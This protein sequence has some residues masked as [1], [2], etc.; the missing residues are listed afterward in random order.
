M[1]RK[2]WKSP[3]LWAFLGIESV[4]YILLLFGGGQVAVISSF[5]SIVLCFL[6]TLIGCKNNSLLAI[7]AMACTVGADFCLVICSPR[8]QLWGMVFFS[9]VQILY[10]IRLHRLVKYKVLLYVR[11]ALILLVEGIAAMVL[12]DGLDALAVISVC[13]YVNLVMNAVAAFC[14]VRQIPLMGVALLLFIACDT[15]IGLQVA[16]DGYLPIGEGSWLYRLLTVDFNLPWVFY[17]PSQVLLALN[18]KKWNEKQHIFR[19]SELFRW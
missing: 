10:A 17:L 15:L 9:A 6:Y 19:F 13:Y 11:L 18:K 3:V 1:E 2:N 8:Q 7:G 12:G 14:A 5:A 16:M 4:L